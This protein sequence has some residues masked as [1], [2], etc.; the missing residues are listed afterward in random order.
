MNINVDASFIMYKI[1]LPMPK[2][3]QDLPC[4]PASPPPLPNASLPSSM[5]YIIQSSLLLLFRFSLKSN[6]D[7]PPKSPPV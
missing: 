4:M 5:H 3:G 6:P 7:L 2:S 1:F